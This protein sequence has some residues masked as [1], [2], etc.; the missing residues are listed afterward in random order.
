MAKRNNNNDNNSNNNFYR[1]II[2]D[3]QIRIP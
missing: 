1:D 2:A 3:S